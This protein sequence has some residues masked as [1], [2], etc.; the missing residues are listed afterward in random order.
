[1]GHFP[2]PRTTSPLGYQDSL[3]IFLPPPS[4]HL[5][6]VYWML[7]FLQSINIIKCFRAQSL[8]LFS[9]CSILTPLI[10]SSRLVALNMSCGSGGK[11]SAYNS[12]GLGLIPG[13][14]RSPGEGNG[15]YGKYG[16]YVFALCVCLVSQLCPTFCNLRDCGPPSSSVHGIFLA[17]ILEWIAISFSKK[18]S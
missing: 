18:S 15:K 8:V 12:G 1:M 17:R 2:F 6:L 14:G 5:I 9:S 10:K 11:T 4:I 7:A 16:K 3:L 13:S